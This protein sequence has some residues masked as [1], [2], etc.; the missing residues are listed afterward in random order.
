MYL[1]G[2]PFQRKK[3]SILKIQ[4]LGQI[5][6]LSFAHFPSLPHAPLSRKSPFLYC[7]LVSVCLSSR[8]KF[9][10]SALVF[11]FQVRSSLDVLIITW[12]SV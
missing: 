5:L 10:V 8:E 2:F 3:M 11:V 9:H 12:F 7:F 1:L 4:S 6:C